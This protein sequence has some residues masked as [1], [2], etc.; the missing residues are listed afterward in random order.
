MPGWHK[1]EPPIHAEIILPAGNLADTLNFFID[2]LGFQMDSI[3]PADDPVIA[4]LSGYGLHL[5]LDSHYQG[6]AGKLCLRTNLF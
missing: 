1:S 4:Q 2:D 6:D 3:T 5:C